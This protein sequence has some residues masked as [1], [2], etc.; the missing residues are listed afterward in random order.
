MHRYDELTYLLCTIVS[1]VRLP[2]SSSRFVLYLSSGLGIRILSV[3]SDFWLLPHFEFP[4]S[5]S[6]KD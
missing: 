3:G 1:E 4:E 2:H 6:S 5:F